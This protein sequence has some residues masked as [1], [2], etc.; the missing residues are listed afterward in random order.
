[1]GGDEVGNGHAGKTDDFL[2]Q[3]YDLPAKQGRQPARNGAFPGAAI[4]NQ[5]QVHS[6][7]SITCRM[8]S[9]GAG[10]PVHSSNCTM[11]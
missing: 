7:A 4:A 3:T 5:N 9:A 6:R 2:I 11:A 10:L 8:A 1:M